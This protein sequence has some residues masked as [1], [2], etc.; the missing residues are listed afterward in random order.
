MANFEV[1]K[2]ENL[3]DFARNS[4][5]HIEHLELAVKELT[6]DRKDLINEV[7]RLITQEKPNGSAHQE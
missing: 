6:Q 5:R 3:V 2:H 1:W 4:Q 7:R